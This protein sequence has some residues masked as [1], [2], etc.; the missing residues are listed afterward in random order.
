MRGKRSTCRRQMQYRLSWCFV[1]SLS[2]HKLLFPTLCELLST[3]SVRIGWHTKPGE[4]KMEVFR[5][6]MVANVLLYNEHAS[7][8]R[9]GWTLAEH[10]RTDEE[11]FGKLMSNK[12]L[13]NQ[14]FGVLMG[15]SLMNCVTECIIRLH[16]LSLSYNKGSLRCELHDVENDT[17]ILTESQG[18]VH[19]RIQ[20]WPKVTP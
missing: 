11:P 2:N 4:E 6:L 7:A 19:S 15:N 10:Q 8:L 12:K 1:F 5:L 16:C 3:F 17:T 13:N 18:W 20:S 14:P 9:T